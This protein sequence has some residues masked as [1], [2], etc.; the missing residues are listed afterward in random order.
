MTT[1]EEDIK[2][3]LAVL[4]GTQP[5]ERPLL[6]D[7]GCDLM[8]HVFRPALSSEVALLEEE[9]RSAV[10]NYEPRITLE[11]VEID[12]SEAADGKLY[13][14][15]QF[16]IDTINSRHNMVFPFYAEEGTLIPTD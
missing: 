12:T 8:T 2:Q 7:Y 13:I 11:E 15:L 16:L 10:V 4:F 9:I 14:Q 1:G 3:S 6:L 5:G